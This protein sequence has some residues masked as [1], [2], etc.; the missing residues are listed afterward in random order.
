MKKCIFIAMVCMVNFVTVSAQKTQVPM[1]AEKAFRQKFPE[2]RNVIWDK[3][4]KNEYEAS[5]LLN[6][7]KGSANFSA[8][9]NWLET[10]IAVPQ[11]AAP[12]KVLEGFGKKFPGAKVNEVFQIYSASGKD[13]FEIEYTLHG[14]KKEARLSAS[15]TVI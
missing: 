15:G 10:E 6:G 2:A 7:K 8:S 12:Q 13:Y 14:K 1:A 9:G 3:E 4:S 5:F 11:A